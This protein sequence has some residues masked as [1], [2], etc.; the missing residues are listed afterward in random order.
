MGKWKKPNSI[1]PFDCLLQHQNN[2][3]HN[4]H[5]TEQQQ[6]HMHKRGMV[7]GCICPIQNFP[8]NHF[9]LKNMA[10]SLK[11]F[12]PILCFM[13][14]WPPQ[15][16][17]I[18]FNGLKILNNQLVMLGTQ[19]GDAYNWCN[20]PPPKLEAQGEV[21]HCHFPFRWWILCRKNVLHAGASNTIL[22]RWN[23][24]QEERQRM[25]NWFWH[26][27]GNVNLYDC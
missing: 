23:M 16:R 26:Q 9:F 4:S 18:L 20:H 15:I 1:W 5:C 8:A 27:Q 11:M 7:A 14:I 12:V 2:C 19:D 13:A 22:G 21:L 10:F 3:D 24:V 17:E 6:G 25:C